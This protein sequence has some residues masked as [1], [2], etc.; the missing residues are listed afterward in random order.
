VDGNA[1][2]PQRA[3]EMSSAV[4]IMAAMA[5]EITRGRS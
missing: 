1:S 4:P 2:N 5:M 3:R